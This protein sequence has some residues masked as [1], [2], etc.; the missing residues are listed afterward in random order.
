MT[1]HRQMST[2]D[3]LRRDADVFGAVKNP[4]FAK[5]T[6]RQAPRFAQLSISLYKCSSP[7]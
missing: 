1:D 5:A 7:P 6:A 4:A 3:Q 2:Q